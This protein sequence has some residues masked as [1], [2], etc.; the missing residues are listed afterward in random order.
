[1]ALDKNSNGMFYDIVNI[2]EKKANLPTFGS[3]ESKT[4]VNSLPDNSIRENSEN[5]NSFSKK[6]AKTNSQSIGNPL[7]AERPSPLS[8]GAQE[9]GATYSASLKGRESTLKYQPATNVQGTE[10]A[11][12]ALRNIELLSG[13]RVDVVL[14]ADAMATA[15]GQQANGEYA[16]GVLY[17]NANADSYERA[18]F[19]ASHELTH[20]LEGTEAYVKLGEFIRERVAADPALAEKYNLNKYRTAYARAQ[21]GDFS[22]ETLEYQADTEMYAD[23]VAREI[24]GNED[25]VRRLVAKERNIA[26]RFL[27]W[28]R[29]ALKRLGGSREAQAEYKAL[30]KAEKLLAAA[31]ESAK[32][33][34]TLEEVEE[35]VQRR[36]ALREMF[37]QEEVKSETKSVESE[38]REVKKE[39]TEQN[40]V[41]V[42]AQSSARYSIDKSFA[43]QVDDVIAGRHS[44]TLDLYVSKTPKV[45]LAIGFPNKPMLM[46]N[47][48]VKEILNK[49]T[50]MNV[51]IIKS[52]PE[53]IKSPIVILKSKTNPAESVV[54]ITEIMTDK[55]EL[56]VPVWIN[57]DGV[58]LDVTIDKVLSEKTNFIA[59]AYGR[60]VKGLLEYAIENDG[61][62]YIN[63]QKEKV[64]NL[65][66]R[67][68][69]QL[70]APLKVS[71]STTIIRENTEKSTENAKKV[72]NSSRKSLDVDSEG[73]ELTKE[74]AEYFK[75]SKARDKNGNLLV[76]YHQA[77]AYRSMKLDITKFSWKCEKITLQFF[78]EILRRAIAFFDYF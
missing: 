34:V 1:M 72:E 24:L 35:D 17:V 45:F 52:V 68:G 55:G 43:E 29:S 49:H 78:K 12:A 67:H 76:V 14:T 47:S 27:E 7:A 38:T 46:R 60:N 5:V 3:Q 66:T 15:D 28:V 59:S 6:N 56:I 41:D 64:E 30:R 54:A 74:Q 71:N 44:P 63:Q 33:G 13:G 32:G 42:G 73:R 48:K 8:Q 11:R 20:S 65:L 19:I 10:N 22:A 51:D 69:L 39:T 50:E 26:V 62:L 36:K 37:A 31:L 25:V 9:S 18:M 77:V 23:F 2:K 16:D 53:A 40:S 70:S 57:Q 58:Y 21:V 75:D 61:F 4:S